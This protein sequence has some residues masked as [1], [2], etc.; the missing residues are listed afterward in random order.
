M[1]ERLL[2][3]P[4][5]GRLALEFSEAETPRLAEAILRCFGAACLAEAWPLAEVVVI[6]GA[7]LIHYAEWEPCLIAQDAAG[8]AVLRRL[9]AAL[10]SPPGGALA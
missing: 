2:T 3:L 10:E 5:S 4:R 1:R 8:D 9:A 6:G 7:R